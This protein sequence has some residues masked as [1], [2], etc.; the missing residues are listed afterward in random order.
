VTTNIIDRLNGLKIQ[1]DQ[2]KTEKTRAE[3]NLQNYTRQRDEVVKEMSELGVTPETVD[4]EIER[5]DQEIEEGLRQAEEL[6]R[7]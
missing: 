6:L 1:I 2:G 7:G 5:L 4:A 3:T